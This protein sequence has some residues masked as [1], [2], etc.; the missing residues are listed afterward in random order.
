MT[1]IYTEDRT[2]EIVAQVKAHLPGPTDDPSTWMAMAFD[3]VMRVTVELNS[4]REEVQELKNDGAKI[5][6]Q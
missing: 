1:E 2:K 3:M 6:L 5:V 4:L